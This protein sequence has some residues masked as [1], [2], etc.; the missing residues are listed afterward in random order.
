MSDHSAPPSPARQNL[1]CCLV[2][3]SDQETLCLFTVRE[4]IGKIVA[5][6][7]PPEWQCPVWVAAP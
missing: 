1:P 7:A 4:K 3:L 2:F 5:M 6:K